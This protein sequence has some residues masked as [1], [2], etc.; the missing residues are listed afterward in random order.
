MIR[1]QLNRQV[2]RHILYNKT[3]SHAFCL[4]L[5]VARKQRGDAVIAPVCKNTTR[6]LFGFSRE[7][8][9]QVKEADLDPGYRQLLELSYHL[10]AN[11]RPAPATEIVKAFNEFFE[12]KYKRGAAVDDMQARFALTAFQYLKSIVDK[13]GEGSFTTEDLQ[14]A[15]QALSYR[16]QQVDTG[17]CEHRPY[18]V[19]IAHQIF[20]ELDGRRKEISEALSM[21]SV[22][23]PYV[24]I[25][26]VCGASILAR[27][28][29]NDRWKQLSKTI[30]RSLWIKILEGFTLEENEEELHRTVEIMGHTGVLFNNAAQQAIISRLVQQD[31][32]ELTKEWYQHALKK[33]D[34]PTAITNRRVLRICI[35]HKDF[36]WAQPIVTRMV[37]KKPDKETWD[38]IFQWA[39][40]KGKGVDE[41]ER[42]MEVMVRRSEQEGKNVQPDTTTINGLIELANSMNDPY[43]AER[44][45]ALAEK[46]NIPADARRCLLQLDYRLKIG[47]IDGARSAYSQLQA[48]EVPN[49]EDIPLINKLI[50]TLC[51]KRG[52]DVDVIMN[53]VQDLTERKAR[54]TPNTIAS[55]CIL[56]LKRN[57]THDLIDLLHTHAFHYGIEERA[58]IRDRLVDFC[59]DRSNSTANAWDAYTI[60]RK[61]FDETETPIRTKL[62]VDFFARGRSDMGTHVFGHMRQF[63]IPA[64]RPT[65]ELYAQCIE[66]IADHADLPSLVTVHNMLKLD[67]EVEPNT[68]LYNALMLAYTACKNPN[69]SLDFWH[70]IMHSRE[71]PTYNSIRIALR[72]CEESAWGKDRAHE[73]RRKLQRFGVE[74]TPEVYAAYVGA[75]ARHEPIQ[76]VIPLLEQMEAE[77]GSAPDVLT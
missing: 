23:I 74:M 10:T 48:Y 31:K 9:R 35:Q 33:L 63:Q 76:E 1:S 45:V 13:G 27:E 11:F 66:C 12:S 42:M 75:V 58:F 26:S 21:D 36:E 34:K 16:E 56:H 55:L 65:A 50:F 67:T 22:L 5:P 7:Q 32:L 77:T 25:L 4:R 38:I 70:D 47:D 53:Y 30:R 72:A 46:L 37:E 71:G 54:F 15:L 8:P 44:Y 20:E 62:M 73:I 61:L 39:S 24:E 69:R 19:E 57:E 43:T 49:G 17:Q 14:V 52:E 51:E 41:V 2:F 40:A 59:L 29:L 18:R 28:L 6:S 3:L 68:K 60:M 64:R